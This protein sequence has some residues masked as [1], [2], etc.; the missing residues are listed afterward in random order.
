MSG[1]SMRRIAGKNDQVFL[2][3]SPWK[4]NTRTPDTSG[5]G[6]G[7][8]HH[9]RLSVD[10]RGNRIYRYHLYSTTLQKHVHDAVSDLEMGK[11]ATVHSLRHSFATH[12]MEADYDIRTVQELLGHTNVQ[13]TMIYTHV[14]RKNK[15]GVIS[16]L[17]K[18]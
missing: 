3:L 5:R 11:R 16:P 7:F 12:P 15:T 1:V 6:I 13:T 8:F 4:E 14:A 10:P 17:Q 18:A 2:S 9:V